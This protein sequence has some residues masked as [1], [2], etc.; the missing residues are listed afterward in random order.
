MLELFIN[1]TTGFIT[2]NFNYLKQQVSTHENSSACNN[3][4][5]PDLCIVYSNYSSP[6]LHRF[7]RHT[8]F[9]K[10]KSLGINW[11]ESWFDGMMYNLSFMD[12]FQIVYQFYSAFDQRPNRG[13]IEVNGF[14][15]AMNDLSTATFGGPTFALFGYNGADDKWCCIPAVLSPEY[16]TYERREEDSTE[17]YGCDV[18]WY[19]WQEYWS[20]P[21]FPTYW[22]EETKVNHSYEIW[23]RLPP[24]YLL[25]VHW[26]ADNFLSMDYERDGDVITATNIAISSAIQGEDPTYYDT[27]EEYMEG[28]SGMDSEV[29][30]FDAGGTSPPPG[31][32]P[33]GWAKCTFDSLIRFDRTCGNDWIPEPDS[34]IGLAFTFVRTE[35]PAIAI[36]RYNI[37]RIAT[38]QGECMNYPVDAPY[39]APLYNGTHFDMTVDSTEL[40]EEVIIYDT[41][42]EDGGVT[43]SRRGYTLVKELEFTVSDT[44]RDILWLKAHDYGAKAVVSPV[45]GQ[46]WKDLM[47]SRTT[48]FGQKVWTVSVPRDDDGQLFTGY[49]WGDFMA[50]YWEERV[51]GVGSGDQKIRDFVP[52]YQGG[53]EGL[54][55]YTDQED[56]PK[57]R[58]INGDG[59]CN[60]EEYRGFLTAGDQNG[61]YASDKHIR[62]NPFLK[63]VMVHFIPGVEIQDEA[64]G[65]IDALMD[66]MAFI[67]EYIPEVDTSS[68]IEL[69]LKRTINYNKVGAYFPYYSSEGSFL[70]PNKGI[71]SCPA[72]GPNQNAVAFWPMY[73]G[74][75]NLSRGSLGYVLRYS[76]VRTPNKVFQCVVRT[77]K[78]DSLTN[79]T[80]YDTQPDSIWDQDREKVIKKTIAHE[81]GHNIG[82]AEGYNQAAGTNIP[83]LMG[84]FYYDPTQGNRYRLTPQYF[85]PQYGQAAKNQITIKDK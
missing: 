4:D 8:V 34:W 44:V 16:V 70:D 62:T 52:F 79:I 53:A 19:R 73:T 22:I 25:E 51:N 45:T 27:L 2:F 76:G 29:G 47:E 7:Y 26:V 60:W 41:N 9:R 33:P 1:L 15:A 80:F 46:T 75:A 72:N 65:Y 21:P 59:F 67:V 36:V 37:F 84:M 23:A 63:N 48:A 30:L 24:N 18:L 66:T 28:E 54:A 55:A 68:S 77:D 81:F 85:D 71:T 39:P 20:N 74:G 14:G 3:I 57:G 13:E 82:M 78:I 40:Y 38:W 58:D 35:I 12:N 56:D 50:D 43:G 17:V 61:Y 83:T 10:Y 64:P 11:Q 42:R 69:R 6:G 31:E 32:E 5:Y 49:N